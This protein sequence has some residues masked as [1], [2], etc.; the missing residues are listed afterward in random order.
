MPAH[1]L[2]WVF[3]LRRLPFIGSFIYYSEKLTFTVIPP[4]FTDSVKS[5]T[6]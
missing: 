1:L 3:L 4:L 6:E 5:P 2:L